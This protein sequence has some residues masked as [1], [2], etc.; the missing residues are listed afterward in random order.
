[1]TNHPPLE[2]ISKDRLSHFITDTYALSGHNL[3]REHEYQ[4]NVCGSEVV[5]TELLWD[6]CCSVVV[7][8]CCE[9]EAQL[10]PICACEVEQW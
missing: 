7:A 9:N 10:V 4:C 5:L 1:M 6:D 2:A 3:F 8:P